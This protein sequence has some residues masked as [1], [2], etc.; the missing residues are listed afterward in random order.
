VG[1]RSESS[2]G[3]ADGSNGFE[4][5]PRKSAANKVKHGVDFN[6]A[7]VMWRDPRGLHVRTNYEPEERWV[8]LATMQGKVWL[9]AWTPRGLNTRIISV[10]RAASEEAAKYHENDGPR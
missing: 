8:L 9:A 3:G 1:G 10:R 5:D 4:Y 7:Q 2:H 6:E